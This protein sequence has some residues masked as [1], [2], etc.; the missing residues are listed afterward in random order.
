M[1]CF[2]IL[3]TLS[4]RLQQTYKN[5]TT[6]V[7][8]LQFK[9]DYVGIDLKKI[10]EMPGAN[11][12]L[13]LEDGDILCIPKQ[14]QIACVNGEA[15][16]PSAVVYEKAKTFLGYVYNAGGFSPRA[17]KSKAYIVYPNGTVKGSHKFLFFT[18][19]L[20]VKPGSNIYVP[21]KPEKKG[22]GT[23][24]VIG[25]TTLVSLGAIILGIISL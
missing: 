24:E 12:D 19:H 15:L 23:T 2:R 4:K 7:D 20:A 18:S 8:S 6:T 5:T 21:L 9:N 13:I 1:K 11:S 14:Q 25:L 3:F 17:L 10:M 22:L 16:Y